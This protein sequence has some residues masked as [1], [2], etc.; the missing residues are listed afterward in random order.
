MWPFMYEEP[1]RVLVDDNLREQGNTI[2]PPCSCRQTVF[3]SNV[4]CSN[5]QMCILYF[6]DEVWRCAWSHCGSKDP[7]MVGVD[8]RLV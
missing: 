5:M 6:E 7:V 8:Q 2:C 1:D 4:M 3:S